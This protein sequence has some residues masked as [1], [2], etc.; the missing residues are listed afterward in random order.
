MIS[1]DRVRRIL[2]LALPIVGGMVSQN[3]LNLVDAAMVGHLGDAALAG[4]GLGGF[5][6]F[7]SSA[8]LLGLSAG[9][10][11]MASRRVGESRATVAAYPLNGGLLFALCL[12]I[13]WS[14]LVWI[15]APRFFALVTDDTSVL[16][17]GV[18]YLQARLVAMTA[19]VMN[20]SFRGYWNAV[21]RSLLY[22]GTL[23]LMHA[24]NIF[25]NWMFI[26]EPRSA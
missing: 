8:L 3:V 10:Q 9:V 21:D 19:M 11:A 14:A 4:V 2:A 12:A 15:S 13:P 6:N 18:P 17:Q 20:F 16:Q 23:I 26:F 5:L 24:L 22:M 7:L 25:F 1:S